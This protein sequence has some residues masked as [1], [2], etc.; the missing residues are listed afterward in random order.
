MEYYDDDVD[1]KCRIRLFKQTVMDLLH[2][3]GP[4]IEMQT[5]RS[6]AVSTTNWLLITRRYYAMG[7]FQR[8]VGDHIHV[9]KSTVCRIIKR[10][11]TR[12]CRL[13]REVV[14]MPEGQ[15]LLTVKREFYLIRNFP[16]VI[17]A[18]DCSHMR[19]QNTGGNGER[20]R[21]RK[22]FFSVNVQAV[23][24]TK[25]KLIDVVTR[26]PGLVHDS[27]IFDACHLRAKFENNEFPNFYQLGESGY[28]CRPYLLTPLQQPSTEAEASHQQ[29]HIATRNPVERLFGVWKKRFCLWK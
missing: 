16:N 24:T 18:L 9:N 14:T 29:S 17:G 21:N 22:G 2:I 12:I 5:R 23:C 19:I 10:V 28:P 25:F 6:M 15:F 8:T 13:R 1:F 4:E 27:A 20:F 26:W 7:A 11:T 3:I